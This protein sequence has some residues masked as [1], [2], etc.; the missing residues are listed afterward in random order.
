MHISTVLYLLA[1]R[2]WSALEGEFIHSPRLNQPLL[3][4]DLCTTTTIQ[5]QQHQQQQKGGENKGGNSSSE[6]A[7]SFE[8][9]RRY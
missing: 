6:Q 2:F 1:H 8:L 5:Q 3:A 4:L 7:M 9:V